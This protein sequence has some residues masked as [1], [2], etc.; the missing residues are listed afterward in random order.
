MKNRPFLLSPAVALSVSSLLILLPLTTRGQSLDSLKPAPVPPQ[1]EAP[2]TAVALPG[3]EADQSSAMPLPADDKVLVGALRGV[4]FFST[5]KSAAAASDE[6]GMHFTGLDLLDTPTFRSVIASYL[7]QPVTRTLLMQV[8]TAAQV[9]LTQQG[10]PFSIAYLPEQDIT[11]GM[12][13]V[14]VVLSRLESEV[15]V[16]GAKYFSPALYQAQVRIDPTAPLN[17]EALR[18]DVA[19]INRNPFRAAS[20]ETRPGKAPGTTQLVLKVREARPW[21]FFAG[22]DNTGTKTTQEERFNAGFN[23]GNAFGRGDQLTA[24]WASSWDFKTLRSGSGSYVMDL[25]WRHTL[26]FSGA[27]SRS[28]GLVSAPFALKGTS[29]QVVADYTIPLAAK[30]PGFTHSLVL[31]IDF[32]SSDNNFT[33]ASIPISNNLT[34]VIQGRVNWSGRLATSKGVTAF[35]ATLAAAPGDLDAHNKDSYFS[36]S[37][38]DAKADYIYL[39]AN[40][41]HTLPLE[42]VVSGLSWMI[43]GQAQLS[44]HNL[45]GSEQFQGG[46]VNSVRGYGEGEVYKDNGMLLSHELRLPPWRLGKSAGQINAYLFEDY[47]HLW[48]TKTLPGEKSTDL[49]SVGL[50]FDYAAGRFVSLRAAYGWQLEDS[51]ANQTGKSSRLHLS[52]QIS[53]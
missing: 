6:P 41:S 5:A 14:V 13:R 18:A 20:I 7:E 3:P 17:A 36:G 47:A 43:R 44:N 30:R 42:K 39:R 34:H 49:H 35:G 24:Q 32:K 21:R 22:A 23:W 40:A 45:I 33:F 9:Y 2:A 4:S 8:T 52:A 26:S 31:G 53:F 12:V 28:N 16:E 15:K 38:S 46:G 48:S 25:P 29:W 19:W 51:G 50:G 10:Y 27:Y 11:A 37:R 1:V